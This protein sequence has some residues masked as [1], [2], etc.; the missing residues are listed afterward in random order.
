MRYP[1]SQ[2]VFCFTISDKRCFSPLEYEA[3]TDSRLWLLDSINPNVLCTVSCSSSYQGG[4]RAVI[5]STWLFGHSET[6]LILN[7]LMIIEWT[8]ILTTP[9]TWTSSSTSNVN[10]AGILWSWPYCALLLLEP[11]SHVWWHLVAVGSS[12]FCSS[13]YKLREVPWLWWSMA[14]LIC[15]IHSQMLYADALL[16][17]DNRLSQSKSSGSMR[18][19]H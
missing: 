12:P 11:Q 8:A 19:R 1:Q 13:R 3:A 17:L 4:K 5:F 15:I 7:H 9:R 14:T 16:R 2:C 10:Q 6:L 18:L